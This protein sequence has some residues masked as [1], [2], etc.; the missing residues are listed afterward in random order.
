MLRSKLISLVLV[1][2]VM[3]FIFLCAPLLADD[4]AFNRLEMSFKNFVTCE[5]TRSDAVNRFGGKPFAI[6]MI[7][8]FEVQT[9]SDIKIITGV[10]KCLVDD[11]HQT[12]YMAVGVKKIMGKEQ[13]NYF[14]IRDKDFSILATELISYPYKERCKWSPYWIDLD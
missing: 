4:F 6:K 11:T 2:G 9:E 10:V 12:L 1:S 3:P 14:T 8:L 7:D 13:V 5:L